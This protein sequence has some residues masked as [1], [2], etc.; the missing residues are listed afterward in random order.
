M[1]GKIL[2]IFIVTLSLLG[3]IVSKNP[4]NETT[5]FIPG[6][7]TYIAHQCKMI[8]SG[9]FM[10]IIKN[11]NEDNKIFRKYSYNIV[12]KDKKVICT[13]TEEEPYDKNKHGKQ[14]WSTS[15]QYNDRHLK[16]GFDYNRQYYDCI[17]PAFLYMSNDEKIRLLDSISVASG[18]GHQ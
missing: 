2:I 5:V 14:M 9:C 15:E 17:S 3:C 8:D 7:E 4:V 10:F 16:N 13:K 11:D 1:N 12:L 6:D 18:Q